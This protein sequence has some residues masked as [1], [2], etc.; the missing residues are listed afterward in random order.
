M[1]SPTTANARMSC[2]HPSTARP[3][4]T[5][6]RNNSKSHLQR[7]TST[8]KPKQTRTTSRQPQKETPKQHRHHVPP[9]HAVTD[10]FTVHPNTQKRGTKGRCRHNRQKTNDT[11]SQTANN[12]TAFH[13][14]QSDIF[15]IVGVRHYQMRTNGSLSHR[16]FIAARP[17]PCRTCTIHT[18][19]TRMQTHARAHMKPKPDA[20]LKSSQSPRTCPC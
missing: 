4:R 9:H 11:I 5:Q 20:C 18:G 17:A 10:A 2:I 19:R 6:Q 13:D 3:R 7:P 15:H 1:C 16:I 12:H 8:N 14:P